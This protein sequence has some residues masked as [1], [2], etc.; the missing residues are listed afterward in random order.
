MSRKSKEFAVFS[1]I[2]ALYPG[3]AGGPPRRSQGWAACAELAL[4]G[5]VDRLEPL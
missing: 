2:C 4:P 5:V 3:R 1:P